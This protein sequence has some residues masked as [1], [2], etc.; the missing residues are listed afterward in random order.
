MVKVILV[1]LFLIFCEFFI[2]CIFLV[3]I[4]GQTDKYS[5]CKQSE[6]LCSW[7]RWKPVGESCQPAWLFLTNCS[8]QSKSSQTDTQNYLIRRVTR[9]KIRITSTKRSSST[10]RSTTAKIRKLHKSFCENLLSVYCGQVKPFSG[11]SRVDFSLS[12]IRE[13]CAPH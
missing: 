10:T 9:D 6:S 13:L 8:I 5:H 11:K 3:F 1:L 4:M 2:F 12:V 7:W